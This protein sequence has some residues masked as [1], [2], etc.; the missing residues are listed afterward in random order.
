MSIKDNS[1]ALRQDNRFPIAFGWLLTA[2]A[3]FI[4]TWV[5]LYFQ[6]RVL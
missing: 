2:T 5:G 1:K 3:I 4:A 6:H